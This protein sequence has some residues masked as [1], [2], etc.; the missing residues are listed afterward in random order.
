MSGLGHPDLPGAWY[1]LQ[2]WAE[3]FEARFAVPRG[4][5]A[6]TFA[7]YFEGKYKFTPKLFGAA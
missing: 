6:D 4:G 7:Y 5:N 2:L 3:F 1:H